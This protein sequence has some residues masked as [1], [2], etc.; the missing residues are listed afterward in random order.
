V[1][2]PAYYTAATS[3]GITLFFAFRGGHLLQAFAII[4]FIRRRPDTGV[5]DHP[6]RGWLG[7]LVYIA[8]EAVPDAGL[9]R[10]SFGLSPTQTHPE[11]RRHPDNPSAGN[12]E[13]LGT[14]P[15]EGSTQV[16]QA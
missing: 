10:Q 6:H 15:E 2:G 11:L 7:A 4:H 5:V 14:S 8:V 1:L 12:Y 3:H 13:E 16:A 9:L